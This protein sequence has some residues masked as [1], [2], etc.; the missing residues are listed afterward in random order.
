MSWITNDNWYNYFKGACT[1]YLINFVC[2]L[3][4]ELSDHR[5]AVLGNTT[6]NVNNRSFHL[7]IIQILSNKKQ[8]IINI[9]SFLST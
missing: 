9:N 3:D 6:K 1:T 5:W 2:L 7:F 8:E 4:E